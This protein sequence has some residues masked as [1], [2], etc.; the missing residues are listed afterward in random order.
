[1]VAVVAHVRGGDLPC[2]ACVI[3]LEAQ[4][5]C[6]IGRIIYL[7]WLSYPVMKYQAR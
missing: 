2:A 1:M 7:S 5:G 4:P 6:K 3:L